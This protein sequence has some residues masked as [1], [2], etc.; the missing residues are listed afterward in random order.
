MSIID[1]NLAYKTRN[2]RHVALSH[3]LCI[4]MWC[5]GLGKDK[6]NCA[7]KS[8]FIADVIMTKIAW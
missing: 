7:L 8:D 4:Q 3:Y 5:F 1:F 2:Q 6:Q